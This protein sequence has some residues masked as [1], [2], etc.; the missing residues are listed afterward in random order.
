MM[1]PELPELPEIREHSTRAIRLRGTISAPLP[2][3]QNL[4][5]GDYYAVDPRIAERQRFQEAMRIAY[6]IT[7]R[8]NRIQ[9]ARASYADRMMQYQ[10]E[11]KRGWWR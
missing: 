3:M 4:D 8:Q 1:I 2:S 6:E 5:L 9:A 10:A 7:R 11:R